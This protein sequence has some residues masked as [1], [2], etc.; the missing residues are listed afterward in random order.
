M[1]GCGGFVLLA[2]SFASYYLDLL[3]DELLPRAP[4]QNT[5]S[6]CITGTPRGQSIC[7]N[8]SVLSAAEGD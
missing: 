3:R 5:V 2:V 6:D 8:F 7:R 1:D 4:G